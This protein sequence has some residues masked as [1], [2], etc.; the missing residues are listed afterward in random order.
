MKAIFMGAP[1]F[2]V[3]ILRALSR[4]DAEIVAVYTKAP[5]Q[6]GRRGLELTKT[7]VHVA[8]E[9]LDL[10][11]E[12]PP[13]LRAAEVQQSLRNLRADVAI[14]AAYGLLLPAEA[15]SAPRLGC[16]NLH[17]SLL[18]RWRGAAPVQRA[19]IAGDRETGVSIMR[20]EVGLDTGPIAGEMRT[21]I[22]PTETA[23]ELTARLSQLAAQT[24]G[25][26]W[27]ALVQERLH[28]APQ[29]SVGVEY[30]RKIEKSEAPINWNADA[31]Q[32]RRQINALSPSP[33]AFTSFPATAGR[34][35]LKL[36]RAECIEGKSG[37]PGEILDEQLAVACGRGAIRAL[38]VQRAG[39][40]VMSG[41]EF[42]RSGAVRVGAVLGQ[43]SPDA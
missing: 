15:L 13:T 11:V 34:E 23:G 35:R 16:Y 1:E 42:M 37:A 22:G 8:A 12:S 27:S 19:I 40:N 14:V 17:A 3:P 36:L 7:P 18:P 6:G 41:D 30:A 21:R 26:N 31:D 25:D 28:F 2:A 43:L 20:M 38:L 29:S 4:T 39:R 33:G 32:L 10:R 24:L 5:R 9:A